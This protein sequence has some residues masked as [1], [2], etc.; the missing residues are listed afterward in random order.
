M[1]E[2]LEDEMGFEHNTTLSLAQRRR[3]HKYKRATSRKG[4]KRK[5][6]G[7]EKEE[8]EEKIVAEDDELV[9]GGEMIEGDEE[10]EQVPATVA[11]IEI[12]EAETVA[13]GNG[14][15]ETLGEL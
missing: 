10:K 14:R 9:H 6:E 8:K 1:V 13:D 11:V 4:E 3:N 5:E 15:T 12:K 7:E 2:V